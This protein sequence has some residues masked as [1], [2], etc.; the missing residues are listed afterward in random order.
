[1]KLFKRAKKAILAA[2]ESSAASNDPHFDKLYLSCKPF[3]MTSRE[4]MFS[5]Y[6]AV[7][8]IVQNNL[9]GDFVECGVWKG[10]SSMMMAATLMHLG[11]TDR[12]IWMYDT[13]EGMSEPTEED[14]DYLGTAADRQLS[15]AKKEDQSSVWCYSSL[16]EVMA[17][18][19]ST[20]YP[21]DKIKYI[22]GKVEDTIPENMPASLIGLLRLDTDWYESTRHEMIHLYPKLIKDGIL[23][24]DDYGHWVGARKAIDDYIVENRLH[25]FLNPIDYTGRIAVKTM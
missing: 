23:I 3:T 8:Y 19:Y 9:P 14:K 12:T 22:K 2:G 16:E 6:K 1:M 24:I 15:D 10:G 13:Y 25:L 20:G 21:K 4:R 11:K 18:M 17:N 7:T 5:L